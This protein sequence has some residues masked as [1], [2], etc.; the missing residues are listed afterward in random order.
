LASLEKT[1]DSSETETVDVMYVEAG[2]YIKDLRVSIVDLPESKFPFALPPIPE[3]K[4]K[5][6]GEPV[7]MIEVL[8]RPRLGGNSFTQSALTR[9]IE[10]NEKSLVHCR[11]EEQSF[12]CHVAGAHGYV[13]ANSFVIVRRTYS[14]TTTP[15]PRSLVLLEFSSKYPSFPTVPLP[16]SMLGQSIATVSQPPSKTLPMK[17]KD[18]GAESEDDGDS[19]AD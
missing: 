14:K 18:W 5:K 13:P 7:M 4:E 15:R 1:L 16:I 10:I 17:L 6:S 19:D 3:E 8:I 12:F 11:R 2:G 9:P